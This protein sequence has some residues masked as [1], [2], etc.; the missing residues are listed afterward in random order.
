MTVNPEFQRN[1]LLEWN[2]HRMILIAGV[3]AGIFVLA[4]LFGTQNVVANIALLT[5]LLGTVLW[6]GHR[7]GDA[8]LD[9][10][11]ERTWDSQK[12][13]AI[14][15]WAMT[16]GKLFG[17][18]I[19][20]WFAGCISLIVYFVEREGPTQIERLQMIVFCI[21][22]AILV[23][24]LSL[25][26]ALVGTHLDKFGKSTL[27]TW[28]SVGALGLLAFYFANYLRSDDIIVWYGA[29]YDRFDF[30][31]A[32]LLVLC[33]WVTFGAYRLM[34]T[35]LAVN[36]LPVAW[37]AF[38]I[39]LIVYFSGVYVSPN[40][41]FTQSISLA[42]AIALTICG[43]SSYIA[44]FA[45]YR[46][47]LA[48]RRLGTCV[49]A[50][51]WRRFFEE[52]PVWIVSMSLALVSVVVCAALHYTPRYS[53]E[54]LEHIG[55]SSLAIWLLFLRDTLILYFFTYGISKRRVETSTIICLAMLYWLIPS[56]IE[57]SGL[58]KTSWLLRPPMKD[59]PLMSATIIAVHVIFVAI[60]V[61]R[62]YRQ[63]IAP[64]RSVS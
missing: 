55:V 30:L 2:L 25:I 4:G 19:M 23:H 18:T 64:A 11:R 48:F 38:L 44:A 45:L 31:T 54:Y 53:G 27:T 39:Y 10:L 42:A 13:S 51:N 59:Q 50:R 1:L 49:R 43:G 17:A 24:S 28:A 21:S 60:L 62:R 32:S 7:A 57:S 52:I 29:S 40:L 36:T 47:P 26:G 3:I 9:E 15:P 56:I 61:L 14:D 41:P 35:E 12:M 63:R 6:G 8:I 58:V 20:P 37:I 16:W 33:A 5:F 46:D 34:C 22:G